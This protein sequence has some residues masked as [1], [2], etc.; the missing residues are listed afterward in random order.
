MQDWALFPREVAQKLK[1]TLMGMG[2]Q[3]ISE[4]RLHLTEK[5]SNILHQLRC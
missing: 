2:G 5:G 3:L 1:H 4:K